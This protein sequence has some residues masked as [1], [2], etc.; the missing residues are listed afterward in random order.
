[1]NPFPVVNETCSS[2]E[3]CFLNFSIEVILMSV[4]VV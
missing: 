2:S 1:M 4:D 3:V